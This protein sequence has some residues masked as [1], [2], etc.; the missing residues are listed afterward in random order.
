VA[1]QKHG[2][3]IVETRTTHGFKGCV[4]KV[5]LDDYH[6]EECNA[7]RTEVQDCNVLPTHAETPS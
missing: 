1:W 2:E 6:S 4:K 5:S 3:A 7:I